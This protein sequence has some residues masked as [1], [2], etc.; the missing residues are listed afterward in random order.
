MKSSF[1]IENIHL[2]LQ[3]YFEAKRHKWERANGSLQTNSTYQSQGFLPETVQYLNSLNPHEV[4]LNNSTGVLTPSST[5]SSSSSSSSSS[6]NAAANTAYLKNDAQLNQ[7][8][9]SANG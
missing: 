5:L 9:L 8:G 7:Q 6:F 4:N 1:I 2:F 3:R